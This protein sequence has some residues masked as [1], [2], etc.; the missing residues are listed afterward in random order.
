MTDRVRHLTVILDRDIR[1]DDV[2]PVMAA[3]SMIQGVAN[4]AAGKLGV[5]DYLARETARLE[6][7]RKIYDALD[8]LLK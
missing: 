1:E 6:L 2:Q 3:V 8:E 4:V 5:G 7:R